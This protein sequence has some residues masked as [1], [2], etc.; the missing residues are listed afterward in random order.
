MVHAHLPSHYIAMCCRSGMRRRHQLALLLWKNYILQKRKLW[1][2]V[3][4]IGLPTIFALILIFIRQKVDVTPISNYTTWE[5]FDVDAL[6]AKL[7]PSRPLCQHGFGP[8]RLFYSPKSPVTDRMMSTMQDLMNR[9]GRRISGKMFL[10]LQF[11][12]DMFKDSN[13]GWSDGLHIFVLESLKCVINWSFLW[14]FSCIS[15]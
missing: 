4:E 13:T 10:Q 3:L 14:L 2:T 6:P 12:Y 7:C 9:D 15:I 11:T 8:W 1:T 5:T